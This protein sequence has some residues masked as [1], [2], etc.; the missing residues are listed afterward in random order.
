MM[1]TIERERFRMKNRLTAAVSNRLEKLG[2]P[3]GSRPL[4][5]ALLLLS[6]S[7]GEALGQTIQGQNLLVIGHSFFVPIAREL[8]AHANRAG[9]VG[10]TQS[11]VFSGGESGTP[12]SLWESPT[13]SA[14]IKSI[15]DTGTV[16]IF[17]MTYDPD[18]EAYEEWIGYALAANPATTI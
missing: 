6:G 3:R 11:E 9:V 18:S 16:D 12:S 7:A 8:P 2:M 1:E 5:L 10:H 13:K 14:E 15:L 17:A 4:L